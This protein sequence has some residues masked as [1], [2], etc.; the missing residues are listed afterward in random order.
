MAVSHPATCPLPAVAFQNASTLILY[1]HFAS[2]TPPLVTQGNVHSGRQLLPLPELGDEFLGVGH[3]ARGAGPLYHT[4]TAY[5][6]IYESTHYSHF[7]FTISAKPPYQLLRVSD[8]FCF[9]A[10]QLP[11][12]DPPWNTYAAY[13]GAAKDVSKT[14]SSIY[15]Y[16]DGNHSQPIPNAKGA[17]DYLHDCESV[18]FA[19]SIVRAPSGEG[20]ASDTLVI[21][22]GAQDTHPLVVTLPMREAI[23]MLVPL[24]PP[25][26]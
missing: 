23:A 12:Y 5:P 13:S 9:R 2:H 20:T 10:Y 26:V 24:P 22:Y 6:S 7:F 21:G 1:S 16:G 11:H 8:E 19:S 17:D 4:P 3:V 15:A 25:G 14:N 18:Q